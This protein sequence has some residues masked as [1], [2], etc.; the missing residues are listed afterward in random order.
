MKEN[1]EE[2]VEIYDVVQLSAVVS[3]HLEAIVEINKGLRDAL[4]RIADLEEQVTRP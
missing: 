1:A 3:V 4:K 2:A